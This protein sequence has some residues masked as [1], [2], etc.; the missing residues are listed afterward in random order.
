M[1]AEICP[2]LNPLRVGEIE[3]RACHPEKG[4]GFF[5]RVQ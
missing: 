5:G 1:A 4:L 2:Y 3:V